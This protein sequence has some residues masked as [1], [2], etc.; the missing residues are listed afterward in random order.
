MQQI[1][2]RTGA[3]S[4]RSDAARD[5]AAALVPAV[6]ALLTALDEV[7]AIEPRSL[8]GAQ[9]DALAGVLA[10]VAGRAGVGQA[11]LL[12]VIEA[13]GLWALGA[14]R[15][16][17]QWAA[18]RYRT[19]IATARAQVRLGRALRDDLPHTA[20]AAVAGDVGLEAARV[21]AAGTTTTPLRREAIA[22]PESSCAEPFLV[23]QARVLPVEDLRT[24]VRA[25]ADHADP[26][27]DDRGYVEASERE[28]LEIA[29]IPY[30]FRVDGQLTVEH[31]EQ[32][33]TALR[34]VMGVPAASDQRSTSQ[35]RAQ[36][37]ADLA[38]LALDH[39]LAGTGMA[40][41]P[42]V[43]VHVDHGTLMDLLARAEARAEGMAA[44]GAEARQSG[45]RAPGRSDRDPWTPGVPRPRTRVTP[46]DLDRGA[47]YEGGTPVPRH[48]LDRL[49]CDSAWARVIFG[50]GSQVL[51]AGR[52]QRTYTGP[53]RSAVIARDQHCRYPGCTAPPAI[54]EVH[55]TRHWARDHGSTAVDEG[56]LLCWHHHE[57]AH[58]RGIL[59]ARQAGGWSFLDR[60][61]VPLRT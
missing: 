5:A 45:T 56:I 2:V 14:H 6:D 22:D 17:V 44:A 57:L 51:D 7:L 21:I 25:W 38:R 32:L 4:E 8:D 61:G 24:L 18:A 31:G 10:S 12:P 28:H 27:A 34:A 35:R 50:P 47:R 29:R 49:A 3:S 37:L 13:D 26:A 19:S 16:L 52:T 9:A 36:G 42:Q 40:V 41:R 43:T 11:R 15:S 30:G 55:H 58:R 48:V 20:D 60:H 59:I 53:K 33:R 54:S 1:F 46:A 23:D 39:G